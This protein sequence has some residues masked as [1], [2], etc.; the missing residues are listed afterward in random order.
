MWPDKRSDHVGLVASHSIHP[1]DQA[2]IECVQLPEKFTC[3]L[4]FVN[5]KTVYSYMD[6]HTKIGPLFAPPKIS[7]ARP[8]LAENFAKTDPQTTFAAKI[9]PAESILAVRTGPP[10]K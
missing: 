1:L 8:I 9:G 5:Y 2:T 3:S 4:P 10:I 7:P 6:C